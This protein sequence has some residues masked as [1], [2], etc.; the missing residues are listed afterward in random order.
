[1]QFENLPPEILLKISLDACTDGGLTGRSLSLVSKHICAVSK[2]AKFHSI[3]IHGV[4]QALQFIQ[5][6]DTIPLQ[7]QPVHHL[8]ITHCYPYDK[9]TR[10]MDDGTSIPR[11]RLGFFG[12]RWFRDDRNYMRAYISSS[13]IGSDPKRRPNSPWT[14]M[15]TQLS[16]AHTEKRRQKI[17]SEGTARFPSHTCEIFAGIGSTSDRSR[18]ELTYASVAHIL[19]VLAPQL[20]DFTS[21]L[22]Q[23]VIFSDPFSQPIFPK[24]TK[25]DIR[26][27]GGS[28]LE[29]AQEKDAAETCYP[30]LES[31]TI[32]D[33]FALPHMYSDESDG[34]PKKPL[35][36]TLTRI[37]YDIPPGYLGREWAAIQA[38]DTFSKLGIGEPLQERLTRPHL[39]TFLPAAIEHITFRLETCHQNIDEC[40]MLEEIVR[41][42]TERDE[43]VHIVKLCTSAARLEERWLDMINGGKESWELSE[44]TAVS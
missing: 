33:F 39:P 19:T 4:W 34:S 43:R 2:P 42:L 38:R 21:T 5:I 32:S 41:E 29:S 28:T 9:P 15:K 35:P 30:S 24:L 10:H 27:V 26:L 1:M 44:N 22:W 12:G 11:R 36:P 8:F 7:T 18:L 31:L 25:L 14:M 23:D 37:S 20:I 16:R 17:I 40:R 6:L 3:A 13:G